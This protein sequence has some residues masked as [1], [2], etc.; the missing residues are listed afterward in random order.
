MTI[1]RRLPRKNQREESL[2]FKSCIVQ[3]KFSDKNPK[4]ACVAGKKKIDGVLTKND[5]PRAGV[6]FKGCLRGGIGRNERCGK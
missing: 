2:G 5:R 3:K 6:V 4:I 1:G